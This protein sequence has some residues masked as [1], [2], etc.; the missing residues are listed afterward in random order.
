VS[1][2]GS[3]DL[4]EVCTIDVASDAMVASTDTAFITVGDDEI[5]IEGPRAREIAAYVVEACNSR[6]A[7]IDALESIYQFGS[8]TLSGRSPDDG[9][10]DRKWQRDAVVEMTK[11]ARIAIAAAEAQS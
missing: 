4:G 1:A 10:D 9:P 11:R 2:L 6:D 7:L 5:T 8:D 3:F